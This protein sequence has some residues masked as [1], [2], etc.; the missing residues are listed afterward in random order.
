MDNATLLW[1]AGILF[2]IV[3]GLVAAI[4]AIV[5][6]AV[7]DLRV[8]QA[9]LVK[10]VNDNFASLNNSVTKEFGLVR[11]ECSTRSRELYAKMDEE[12]KERVDKHDKSMERMFRRLEA[13]QSTSAAESS[14]QKDDIGD[15]RETVAGFGSIYVTRKEWIEGCPRSHVHPPS[16]PGG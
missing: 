8:K 4:W 5:W 3:G 13:L 15:I 9:E 7:K 11:A 6:G 1:V 12:R 14:S 16:Q 2:T 10:S